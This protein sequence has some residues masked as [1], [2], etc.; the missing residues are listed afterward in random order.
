[1]EVERRL[2]QLVPH[3]YQLWLPDDKQHGRIPLL[4][5]L[6]GYAGDMISMMRVARGVAGDE[7]VVASIQGP[8]QFFYPTVEA[9]DAQK[10]AFGWQ[11]PYRAED[12]LARHHQLVTRVI[13][14]AS[15]SHRADESRVFLMGFSQACAMNYRLTFTRP[16]LLRG[17]IGVCGGIPKDFSDPKYKHVETS[18]LHIG[19][20]KDQFYPL[21]RTRSFE[22][23]L[24]RLAQDVTYHEYDAPHVFPRR[25]IPFIRRW[26]LERC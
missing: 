18:V 4:I 9:G 11:T 12:S 16:G 19:A 23:A 17:V 6:H 13:R 14:E 5:A 8:H 24:R 2:M 25:A 20:T 1:M 3:Y 21:D 7:M 22:S 10:I 15:A 26:M